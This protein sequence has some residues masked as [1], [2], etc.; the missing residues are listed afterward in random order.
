MHMTDDFYPSQSPDDNADA[1]FDNGGFDADLASLLDNAEFGRNEK[2]L[3]TERAQ[4]EVANMFSGTSLNQG[5]F[6]EILTDVSNGEIGFA[7]LLAAYSAEESFLWEDTQEALDDADQER[8]ETLI[9]F[10]LVMTTVIARHES[11]EADNIDRIS[12]SKAK[13]TIQ[14]LNGNYPALSA[15]DRAELWSAISKMPGDDIDMFDDLGVL[16]IGAEIDADDQWHAF[17]IPA[18]EKI[19]DLLNKELGDTVKH[20][21]LGALVDC[22]AGYVVTSHSD[23]PEGFALMHDMYKEGLDH[24]KGRVGISDGE[25]LLLIEK[26]NEAITKED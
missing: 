4:R 26:A 15:E 16:E 18:S 5:A 12:N 21:E 13:L 1:Y 9:R 11:E 6:G 24:L 7:D 8:T 20:D 22:I 14:A 2:Y 3:I 17:A 25:I 10:A 19:T 23:C